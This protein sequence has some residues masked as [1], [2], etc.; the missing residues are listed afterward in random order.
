MTARAGLWLGLTAL[1]FAAPMPV[2]AEEVWFDVP[3][4]DLG[5]ALKVVAEQ[6]H[7][8]LLMSSDQVR[9]QRSREVRGRLP[10]EAAFEQVL[11]DSGLTVRSVK[12][13][14]FVIVPAPPAPRPVAR[15]PAPPAAGTAEVVVRARR[16]R[17]AA[18]AETD[19][20]G[21]DLLAVSSVDRETLQR[22]PAGNALDA[23]GLVSGVTLL[24][25]GRSFIGGADGASRG[26]SLYL[27]SRGLDAEYS[28][29]LLDGVAIAQ[30]MPYSR[31]VQ[32]SL[33]PPEAL[34]SVAV[35]KSASAAMSGDAIAAT[36]DWRTPTA[37][38]FDATG[39]WRLKVFAGEEGRARDYRADGGGGGLSLEAAHRFGA[40]RSLGLYV[41]VF[42]DH[43]AFANSEIA[44]IMTAQNDKAW[45][46]ARAASPL[47]DNP[48]GLAP[49]GNLT[50]TGLDFGLSRGKTDRSVAIANLDWR[51]SES[52]DGFVHLMAG[53]AATAQSS[54]LD[55][56]L[57]GSM[58]W[59]DD[60]EGD[61]RISIDQVSTRV[62]YETNPE[63]IE[64]AS[65]NAGLR[66]RRGALTL[67]PSV[68]AGYARFARPSH[69]EASA[70]IDQ[71]DDYNTGNAMRPLGGPAIVYDSLGRPIPVLTPDMHADLDQAGDRLLARRAG[72]L[73]AQSSDQLRYGAAVDANWTGA[74]GLRRI[75]WGVRYSASR[76][77]SDER[78]WRND[79]IANGAGTAGLTW[80][81]LG[82]ATGAYAHAVPGLFD[83]RLPRVDEQ[84]LRNLFRQYE[85]AASFDTCGTL[86]VNNDN[87]NSQ[88][89]DENVAA[90]Y[91]AGH[92][93]IGPVEI[94]PGW[95][96]EWTLI[97]NT[98]W[99]MAVA[100]GVDTPGSWQH[101]ASRYNEG[102]PSLFATWTVRGGPVVRLGL[103]R[104]Y[105]RPAF[106][107]LAGGTKTTQLAGVTTV[108][109]GNPDLR[110]VT[111]SNADLSLSWSGAKGSFSVAAY[112][113][114]LKD[115]LY[116]RGDFPTNPTQPTA[117]T[118]R[119]VY[120]QNAGAGTARG[121]EIE[122]SL[123]LG[124][125][126]TASLTATR[127][128]T[129]VD[130]SEALGHD[131]PMPNAPGLIGNLGLA[132]RGKALSGHVVYRY[133]SAYLSGYDA[134][135]INAPWD[136]QWVRAA[137]RLD[138]AGV[139]VVS[140]RLTLQ[141][142][143]ENLLGGNFYWSH[144][145]KHSLA[146]SDIVDSGRTWRLSA[147]YS[148]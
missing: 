20:G 139:W 124:D 26:E 95:R 66:W 79:F 98:Y 129:R 18:L 55:E 34:Q 123:P 72:Q 13:G 32:M 119:Y 130:L 51:P 94:V 49:E 29:N 33:L 103:W 67:T 7:S 58:T 136:D 76:R 133:T 28:L 23:L 47:G 81:G 78:D 108:E 73:T 41:S 140:R 21:A 105:S 122:A 52:L 44:G 93:I 59:R 30:G 60:G 45:G 10:A 127:Q 5:A 147:I 135:E 88:S 43:R 83:W 4:Q 82:V 106:S 38:D 64:L 80:S 36:I 111:A 121:L 90:A 84:R 144:V 19:G 120:P 99:A 35:Y 70:R 97:H 110:P 1:I 17:L 40:G 16:L 3:R 87:C 6:S 12:P 85:T 39:L 71:T 148:F 57:P 113:K 96:Q 102:L 11:R 42:S 114:S 77:R 14:T 65:L 89:G 131:K 101:S 25:T 24:N 75:E 143:A 145:G 92:F 86:Y 117:G 2:R 62:W 48:R 116:D 128:W 109:T 91:V 138:V 53:K 104:A 134:L 31:A 100:D 54:T 8:Q 137:A 15:P 50:L 142:S 141:A 146:I 37:F 63:T 118:L 69:L 74:G 112:V 46:F 132:Y 125:H 9:G 126:L 68:F 27:A 56:V 22:R 107:Q 61:Y 115:F